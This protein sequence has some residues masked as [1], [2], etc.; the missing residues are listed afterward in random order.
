MVSQTVELLKNEIP[1]EQESVVLT[2]ATI[3]GLVLVDIING[4]CTAPKEANRQISGM[5]NKSERLA[6]LFCE[7]KFSIMALL[8]SHHPNKDGSQ[9]IWIA[10]SGGRD[11]T[12]PKTGEFVPATTELCY[13]FE[14]QLI[15]AC[16]CRPSEL[17][18]LRA[19]FLNLK[20]RSTLATIKKA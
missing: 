12:D 6:R 14:L 20:A 16:H 13:K 5:I 15:P 8:D 3:N 10:P 9:L 17:C 18:V 2:E 7:K 19:I 4:F 1:L 11:R